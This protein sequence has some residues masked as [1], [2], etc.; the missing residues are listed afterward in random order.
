[1]FKFQHFSKVPNMFFDTIL[2]QLPTAMAVSDQSSVTD[3]LTIP[4]TVNLGDLSQ[5]GD[6]LILFTALSFMFLH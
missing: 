4:T 3:A 6:N 2:L 1:M 5:E